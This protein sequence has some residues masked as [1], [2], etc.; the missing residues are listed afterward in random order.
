MKVII[1]KY[2][3]KLNSGM[4][5]ILYHVLTIKLFGTIWHWARESKYASNNINN[6]SIRI[7]TYIAISIS[8]FLYVF[9]KTLSQKI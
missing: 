4:Q 9:L 7:G 2:P 3:N 6:C 8:T 1:T 5:P